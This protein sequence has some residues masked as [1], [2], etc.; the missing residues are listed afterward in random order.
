MAA[1]MSVAS[2]LTDAA[3]GSGESQDV[4]KSFETLRH[5][6]IGD[7]INK[8]EKIKNKCRNSEIDISN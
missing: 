8:F 2:P 5:K 6:Y 4:A 1:F 3:T 7:Y